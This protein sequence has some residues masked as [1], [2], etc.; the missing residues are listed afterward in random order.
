MKK[1]LLKK[2]MFLLTLLFI[3]SCSNE[4]EKSRITHLPFQ[5]S[6][7]GRWGLV[8]IDGKVLFEEE[9][10]EM[11]TP[12]A[13]GRFFVKN[14][15][16]DLWE[17]YTAEANPKKIGDEYLSVSDFVTTVTPVVKKGERICLIDVN[18]NVK[19]ILDKVNKKNIVSCST[20]I[21]G[22]AI[23]IDEDD[24]YGVID[25]EGK[26][27]I[28]PKYDRL[29]P[30]GDDRFIVK[31]ESL[32]EV[33][34]KAGKVLMSIEVGDGKRYSRFEENASTSSYF[35]VC[36]T[37]N[38]EREWGYIDI[39]KDVVVKPSKKISYISRVQ[40]DYFI[41]KNDNGYGVAD[42]KGNTIIRTKYDELDWCGNGLLQAYKYDYNVENVVCSI[43]N[44][45][46][47]KVVSDK[48]LSCL[49]FF[50][51]K[52][53]A[54]KVAENDWIFINNK[55]EELSPQEAPEM[56][57]IY[58]GGHSYGNDAF[59]YLHS[60]YIDIDKIISKLE[61]KKDGMWGCGGKTTSQE[62]LDLLSKKGF[63]GKYSFPDYGDFD[64]YA[65]NM[66]TRYSSY[67][68]Q[69][70]Y[71]KVNKNNTW[72]YIPKSIMTHIKGPKV[73]GK[74]EQI[75]SKIKNIIKTFGQVVKENSRAIIVK[76]TDELGWIA[77]YN[78]DQIDLRIIYNKNYQYFYIEM[79][80]SEGE[81]TKVYIDSKPTE[82]DIMELFDM[83]ESD[84]VD[85]IDN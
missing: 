17:M 30:V 36:T 25:T 40:G 29:T 11:P 31:K 39:N 9:F 71:D 72:E 73:T 76:V 70:E 83:D 27:I 51:G 33:I 20:F 57:Y 84:P 81:K 23:I 6:E 12:A 18:G 82:D 74:T 69:I 46:G 15:S 67:D 2:I 52:H 78:N 8:G 16:T 58:K 80:E 60:D 44:L 1:L 42:F 7:N 35:A 22:Y 4:T 54:V 10:K 79:F 47:E 48:Y 21:K 19:T 26:V 38:G 55:G 14:S 37:I 75:Y 63:S 41:F 24:K 28:N 56:Y 43:I 45:K 13:N 64:I 77:Y 68:L 59:T 32:Y 66:S 62:Q 85:S 50:D 61:L 49:D 3:V 65:G 34:D 53:A 5:S